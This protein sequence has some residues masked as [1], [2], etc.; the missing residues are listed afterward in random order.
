MDPKCPVLGNQ[1]PKLHPH[2]F[3]DVMPGSFFRRNQLKVMARKPIDTV[4][5]DQS[6]R[7]RAEFKG[8]EGSGRANGR[9]LAH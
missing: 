6:L 9:Y 3:S 4:H 7:H 1:A 5:M 8:V 2:S